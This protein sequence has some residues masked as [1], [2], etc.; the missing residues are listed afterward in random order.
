MW[1]KHPFLCRVLGKLPLAVR[2]NCWEICTIWGEEYNLGMEQLPKSQRLWN[3]DR[4]GKDLRCIKIEEDLIGFN[5]QKELRKFFNAKESACF[6]WKC[7]EIIWKLDDFLTIFLYLSRHNYIL[8][9]RFSSANTDKLIFL[10]RVYTHFHP[11]L[12]SKVDT[13]T[14]TSIHILNSHLFI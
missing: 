1:K 4:S 9:I 10:E 11:Y 3:M 14:K 8:K 6:M 13:I 12:I 7:F 5:W 2:S